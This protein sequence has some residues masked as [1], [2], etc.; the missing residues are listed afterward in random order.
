MNLLR[1]YIR[2][3][4]ESQAAEP[5]R[6]PLDIPI[7]ADLKDI[8]KRMKYAGRELFLVGGAVRDTL[9]GKSP[10][11][12][13]V[14]TNASPEEVIKILQK[15][16]Q[17]KLDLT[18][19]SFG[20]VRVKTKDGGEYEIATFREDIGK[21]KDTSVKFSTIEND[22]LR[23]DLTINALF[24]DMDSREVVDYVGGI[25][26]IEDGI[27]RAVGEPGQRFDEDRIRILRAARFAGRMGSNLDPATKQAILEDNALIDTQTGQPIP[28]DRITEEFIKGIKSAQDVSSFLSLVQ[29]L[30][31]FDQI[32][33]GL[34]IELSEFGSQD[35]IAQIAAILINNPPDL[36]IPTLQRMRYSNNDTK[37]ISFLLRLI[38]LN[39]ETAAKLKKDFNRLSLSPDHLENF[40]EITGT[41]SEAKVRGFL[42]F[43]AA[44]L[45]GDPKELMA[46]GL[47]G[48]EIGLAMAQAEADAY[49]D[50]IG[51]VRKYVR[52]LLTEDPMGFVHDLAA[53]SKEFG[54][55]GE[56]FFGGD[57]GRGGGK[58][59]KRAFNANADHAWLSTLNTVHWVGYVDDLAHLKG[60]NKDE[61]STVMT[62]PG[63]PF[64]PYTGP[65]ASVGLWVKGRITLATNDMDQLFS[66]NW[67][68]YVG[69]H[70]GYTD[71]EQEQR[72]KSSGVNKL[73]HVSKDY[74]RYGQLKRGDE[75]AENMARNMPY[76]LDK[77][78]W[79]KGFAG[80]TN[81]ALVDNWK[82]VGVVV[83]ERDAKFVKHYAMNDPEEAIGVMKKL[84]QV[85]GEFGV[86][87][88]DISGIELWSP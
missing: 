46:K 59:I 85:A 32:L 66:G 72:Q 34:E 24:Y 27:I 71:E 60:Q 51:E 23:R 40:A 67:Y 88:Y 45:A 22:V 76:V 26:D 79:H 39:R 65:Q 44:P 20:V 38:N 58:A 75:F 4:V 57:P 68:D 3:L 6:V 49:A 11:D 25:K 52:E 64:E 43:S 54:R 33:P 47:K 84:F 63:D 21:G 78:T 31:L 74:S 8:H 81:E 17:L 7:P 35:H 69:A 86:P 56:E 15:D 62:L 41:P 53:A 55:E 82:A 70:S 10:K 80:E 61:L 87:I 18:G 29:E 2:E 19:K 12:Y 13:D 14:A 16:P 36:V 28:A 73:P 30:E 50:F 83:P 77:S 42:E 37:T 9:L 48:P 5:E 1:E